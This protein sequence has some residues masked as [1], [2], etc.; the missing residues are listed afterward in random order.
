MNVINS[1]CCN[2]FIELLVF[3]GDDELLL[4]TFIME[5]TGDL[6]RMIDGILFLLVGSAT[7]YGEAH[8]SNQ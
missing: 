2:I 4:N 8:D 3:R 5:H 7:V 6:S 1:E